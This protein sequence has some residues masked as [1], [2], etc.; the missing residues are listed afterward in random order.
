[1]SNVLIKGI[2]M[3]K[4]CPQCVA[5]HYNKIGAFTGCN[6]VP[7][8]LY[9]I[10]DSK[11]AKSNTRP[12]WCPLVEVSDVYNWTPISTAEPPGGIHVLATIQWE[13]GDLDVTELDYGLLKATKW[14]H[15]DKVIA[16]APMPEPYKEAEH[17]CID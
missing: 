9:A 3:P 15:L 5:A 1:M 13:D 11:Y 7:G 6:V 10:N 16:W 12:E 8:K 4:D 14:P 2:E 17:E